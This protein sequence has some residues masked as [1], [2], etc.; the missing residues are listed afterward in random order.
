MMGAEFY[1][2]KP[3]AKREREFF[4]KGTVP[5]VE[6]SA[7]RRAHFRPTSGRDA[8]PP[9]LKLLRTGRRVLNPAA[10]TH[11]ISAKVKLSIGQSCLMAH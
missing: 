9:S 10:A 7:Q 6:Q 4:L 8:L 11:P 2:R 5:L 3:I 1:L